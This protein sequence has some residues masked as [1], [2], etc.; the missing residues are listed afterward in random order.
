MGSKRLGSR[1]KTLP[2]KRPLDRALAANAKKSLKKLFAALTADGRKH[3]RL[4]FTH[5]IV[6]QPLFVQTSQGSPIKGLPGPTD[7]RPPIKVVQ[8]QEHQRKHRV[9]DPVGVNM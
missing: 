4:R 7:P 2:P 6:D 3:Y 8:R 9:I 1:L 5:R